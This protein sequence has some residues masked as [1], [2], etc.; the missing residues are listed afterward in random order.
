MHRPTHTGSTKDR[1]LDVG[2]SYCH[3]LLSLHRADTA[4]TQWKHEGEKSAGVFF[5][6]LLHSLY[7]ESHFFFYRFTLQ[8]L[9]PWWIV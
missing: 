7:S 4:C 6:S 5:F 8:S 1:L 3:G 9:H 2:V